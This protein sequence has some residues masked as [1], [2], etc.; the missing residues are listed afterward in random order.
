MERLRRFHRENRAD[1]YIE[2]DLPRPIV[3][4]VEEDVVDNAGVELLDNL[5]D[6]EEVRDDLGDDL[7]DDDDLN[8][9]ED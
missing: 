7:G 1:P 9:F 3:E 6:F 4:H 5:E 2:G 8:D